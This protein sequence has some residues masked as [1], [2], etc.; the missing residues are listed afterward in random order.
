MSRRTLHGPLSSP[1][2]FIRANE[3]V[4]ITGFNILHVGCLFISQLPAMAI[5]QQEKFNYARVSFTG[6]HD[7]SPSL[8]ALSHWG[9]T[10]TTLSWT[11]RVHRK[12]PYY[13]GFHIKPNLN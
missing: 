13:R 12:C 9:Y 6:R 7:V 8:A 10:Q 11:L 4:V 2:F 3:A 5:A 1:S